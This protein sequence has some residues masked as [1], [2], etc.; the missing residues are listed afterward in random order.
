LIINYGFRT[1]REYNSAKNRITALQLQLSRT[2]AKLRQADVQITILQNRVEALTSQLAS[3]SRIEKQLRK[4]IPDKSE[5]TAPPKT[6][7]GLI[8]A[9]LYTLQG[10]SV[11]IDD[12]ILY[13]GDMI[14][15]VK[16]AKIQQDSVEFV[17]GTY[18]WTQQIHQSPPPIWTQKNK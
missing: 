13:E 17:K 3:R 18:R 16:I 11:V 4:S 2:R 1:S 9:I 6:T 5:R 8:T 7:R 15:G 10:S 14:H 12:V